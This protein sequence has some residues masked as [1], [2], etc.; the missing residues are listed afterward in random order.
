MRY[1]FILIY[2]LFS[3]IASAQKDTGSV[4]MPVEV[5]K[6]VAQDLIIGDSAKAM[7]DVTI[8]ELDLTK[9]K[10]SYKDSLIVV[11]KLKEINLKEQVKNERL[12]K[13]G[14]SA[15]YEDSKK[16]FNTLSKEYKRYK[17]KK[18]FTDIL[19]IGGLISL[20]GLLIYK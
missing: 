3:L 18:K 20:L 7:L 2:T 17:V 13:E 5:A 14:F 6:Q 12:E 1:V 9:E 8:E 16:Q 15:L 10:L 11:A 4:C 19:F